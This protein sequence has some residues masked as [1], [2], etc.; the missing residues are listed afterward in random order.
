MEYEQLVKDNPD[1]YFELVKIESSE[2]CLEF[3]PIYAMTPNV[4]GKGLA[5]SGRNP[6]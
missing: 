5:Y 6:L 1:T 2:V 4:Q 3:T